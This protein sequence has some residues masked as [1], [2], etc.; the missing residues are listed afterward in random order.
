[1][2]FVRKG[3]TVGRKRDWRVCFILR[4]PE[5]EVTTEWDGWEGVRQRARNWEDSRERWT[6]IG[7]TDASECRWSTLVIFTHPEAIRRAAFCAVCSLLREVDLLLGNHI[8]DA[9]VMRDLMSDL[10]VMISVSFCWP[11]L[12]PA[13]ARMMLRR[14]AMR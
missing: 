7:R 8:G 1:M 10:N 5:G 4:G 2:P 9:Y 14:G 6:E 13:R 3:A 11:Q 12:V